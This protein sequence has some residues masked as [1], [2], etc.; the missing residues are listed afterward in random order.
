M[1]KLLVYYGFSKLTKKVIRKKELSI[2]YENCSSFRN[3]EY[4]ERRI[5]IAYTRYQ[6]ADELK[7]CTKYNR[8]FT[9]YGYFIDEKPYLG[10]INYVLNENFKAEKNHVSAEERELIKEKLFN[11]YFEVYNLKKRPY[12]QQALIF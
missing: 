2:Y 3:Q 8:V 5:I 6:T 7:D 1:K 9:K 4:I 10:D 11:S 12:G